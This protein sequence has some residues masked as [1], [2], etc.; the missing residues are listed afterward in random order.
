MIDVQTARFVAFW[1]PKGGTPSREWEDGCAYSPRT[2]WFA[3]TDGASTG[4]RSREWAYFV[5]RCFVED[6]PD[7]L[8]V[9]DG[10]HGERFVD[11]AASLRS[12][13]DPN[14]SEFLPLRA[15]TWVRAAGEERGAFCTFLG[16]RLTGG[17][18][19]ALA[20]GD[21]CL[22]HLNGQSGRLVTFPLAS[23]SDIG[24]TPMLVPSVAAGDRRL[25]Q[26]VR[27]GQGRFE[28]DDALFVATDALSEWMLDAREHPALWPTLGRITSAGFAAMC[29]D[30]RKAGQM[31]NDDVT[32]LRCIGPRHPAEVP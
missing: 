7:E 20:V 25:R 21:C 8:L 3:V 17:G 31:R 32:L 16:G 6:R 19:E 24:S 22:F 12:R 4:I 9:P 5:A 1:Q 11:W 10:R 27:L 23:P 15:P 28:P 18:W 13:F 29:A 30:L 26:E 14:A 2:G